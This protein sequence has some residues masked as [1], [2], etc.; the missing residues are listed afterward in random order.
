MGNRGME[1]SG[2]KGLKVWTY[3]KLSS[4]KSLAPAQPVN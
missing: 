1:S 4:G 2:A 3:V